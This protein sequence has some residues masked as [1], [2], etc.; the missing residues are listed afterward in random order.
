[1]CF[2]ELRIRGFGRPGQRRTDLV[3]S[4]SFIL[5]KIFG[6]RLKEEA[7]RATQ[8]AWADLVIAHSKQIAFEIQRM[9]A[10]N[11][12]GFAVEIDQADRVAGFIEGHVLHEEASYHIPTKVPAQKP[13]DSSARLR[14]NIFDGPDTTGLPLPE[15]KD[16]VTSSK[17]LIELRLSLRQMLYPSILEE[18]IYKVSKLLRERAPFT[19]P[20][21]H[22]DIQANFD[23]EWVL[24]SF[25]QDEIKGEMGITEKVRMLWSVIT[26]TG[27]VEKA[28]ATT[29]K[30]YMRW[31]WPHTAQAIMTAVENSLVEMSSDE[32]WAQRDTRHTVLSESSTMSNL[33]SGSSK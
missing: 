17:A 18:I 4:V 27:N 1:M 22:H 12:V 7:T 6:A 21:A 23:V 9:D 32:F 29:C 3:F 8:M 15:F 25:V 2:K 33:M 14:R 16:F 31:K 30:E 11:L 13:K 24:S 10:F 20:G 5:V 28:W 26:V 19:S